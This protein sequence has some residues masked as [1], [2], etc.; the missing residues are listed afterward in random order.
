MINISSLSRTPLYDLHCELGGKMVPF[1][2]Y[3]MPV[4]YTSGIIK[5]HLHTRNAASLFDVSHMGQVNLVGANAISSLEKLVPVD[6]ENLPQNHSTYALFTNDTGGILDDLIITRRAENELMLVVNAACKHQDF[7]YLQEHI[8]KNCLLQMPKGRALLALQGPSAAAIINNLLPET[9][10]LVFMRGCNTVLNGIN[11]YVTRSGYTGEDGFELSIEN[12]DAEYIARKLLSFD[13]V[14]LAGLGARDSLRL[15]A[16]MCLYGHDLNTETTPIDASLQWS[17][18]KSRRNDGVKKGGF[19]GADIILPQI[20]YGNTE[21]KRVG[22]EVHGRVPVRE[23]AI[24]LNHE[25]LEVGK[26]TSGG[27]S[28]SLKKPIAMGYVK[29]TQISN[30]SGLTTVIR[31]KQIELKVS[32]MPFIPHKYVRS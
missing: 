31:N 4:Q 29:S 28:P 19:P 9:K 21:Y 20:Q 5:E 18:A 7:A 15:E 17:I 23:G 13:E 27:F 26:I 1:A 11:I 12:K 22:F 2:G 8:D 24:V 3:E 6:L 25:G 10:N 32:A 16:G 14:K 30:D